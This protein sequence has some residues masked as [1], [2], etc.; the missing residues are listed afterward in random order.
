[1]G[2]V[3]YAFSLSEFFPL[4]AKALL[5]I[6]AEPLAILGSCLPWFTLPSCRA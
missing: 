5:G 1:M 3:D 2:V 6:A 4:R